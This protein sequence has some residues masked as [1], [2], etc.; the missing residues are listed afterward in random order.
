M[1]AE[2]E[3][4]GDERP[5]LRIE[6]ERAQGR[7]Q[8]AQAGGEPGLPGGIER[9]PADGFRVAGGVPVYAGVGRAIR[10]LQARFGK[11]LAGFRAASAR[12]DVSERRIMLDDRRAIPADEM[13]PAEVDAA[14][15]TMRGKRDAHQ[16][17]LFQVIRSYGDKEACG[18]SN[19]QVLE[20]KDR[21]TS[22]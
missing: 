8:R 1:R 10:P 16:D 2:V 22:V 3:G 5:D 15:K 4:A 12:H 14:D 17:L 19:T 7:E 20:P 18:A 13:V 6:Q 9:R 21:Q 11:Q